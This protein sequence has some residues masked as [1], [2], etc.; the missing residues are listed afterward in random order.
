MALHKTYI[1][2]NIERK[3]YES[4]KVLCKSYTRKKYLNETKM[5]TLQTYEKNVCIKIFKQNKKLNSYNNKK[6]CTHMHN[7]ITP[8]NA[9][10][11]YEATKQSLKALILLIY[12]NE[13]SPM[14]IELD[15]TK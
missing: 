1:R 3:K 15:P 9:N 10:L 13:C 11:Y 6:K 12:E 14:H 2:K 8:T 5:V 4:P 7:K